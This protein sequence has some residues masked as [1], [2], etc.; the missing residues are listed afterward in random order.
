MQAQQHEM[1][2][3]VPAQ[4]QCNHCGKIVLLANATITKH[5]ITDTYTE[6]EH[7]CSDKCAVEA[8]ETFYARD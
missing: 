2:G 1:F 5:T 6:T 4:T 7:H 8:W 3:F